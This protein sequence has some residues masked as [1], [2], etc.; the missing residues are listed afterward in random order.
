MWQVG[1]DFLVSP[2]D[3]WPSMSSSARDRCQV[4]ISE[5]KSSEGQTHLVGPTQ[6]SKHEPV[7][8]LYESLKS[9]STLGAAVSRT[10]LTTL[11][12]EKLELSVRVLACVLRAILGAD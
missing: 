4:P 1:P 6:K 5:C 3:K 10:A 9:P 8:V 2:F 7:Q 12:R 11:D